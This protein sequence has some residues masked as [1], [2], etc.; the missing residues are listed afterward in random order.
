M[1]QATVPVPLE[2]V[3]VCMNSGVFVVQQGLSQV[4]TGLCVKQA[5]LDC[6]DTK[7]ADA[8]SSSMMK[9]MTGGGAFMGSHHRARSAERM[10]R[11]VGGAMSAA[12]RSE[13]D[14][15]A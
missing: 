10:E 15:L 4:F 1:N 3:V 5:V 2:M 7:A 12:G 9:R 14:K 13:L 11:R 8:I 6:N